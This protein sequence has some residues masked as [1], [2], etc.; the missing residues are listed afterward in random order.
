M[1]VSEVIEI[2]E[3][4]RDFAENWSEYDLSEKLSALMYY[5]YETLED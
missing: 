3:E 1:E 2:I 5:L 4:A